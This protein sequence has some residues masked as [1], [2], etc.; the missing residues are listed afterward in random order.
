LKLL[1]G[2]AHN[3]GGPFHIHQDNGDSSSGEAPYF[4]NS[5]C[6]NLTLKLTT[7]TVYCPPPKKKEKERKEKKRKEKKRK[8]KRYRYVFFSNVSLSIGCK[9]KYG[10]RTPR[11]SSQ[12]KRV[13]FA[14]E[15]HR[16]GNKRQRQEVMKE[17]IGIKEEWSGIFFLEENKGLPFHREDTDVAHRI[18]T[19]Y[20][21]KEEALC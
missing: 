21:D 9:Q 10:P 8:K 7:K 3:W 19:V 4:S 18:V 6:Y 15:G 16:A 11:P 2:A 20:K 5:N 1:E 17:G 12:H 14:T 13:L